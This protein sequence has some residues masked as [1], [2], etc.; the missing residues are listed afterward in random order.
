VQSIHLLSDLKDKFVESVELQMHLSSLDEQFIENLDGLIQ[1]STG[2][3][4]V[5]F[6]V[7]DSMENLKVEMRSKRQGISLSREFVKQLDEM[8]NISYVL[9]PKKM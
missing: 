5:R 4:K 2:N 7:Y 9:N 6:M 1:S 3:C 8:K